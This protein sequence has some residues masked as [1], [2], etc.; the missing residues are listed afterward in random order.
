ML[1]LLHLLLGQ[2]LHLLRI[3]RH[4]RQIGWIHLLVLQGFHGK[5]LDLFG[6]L[7]EF[8]R[9]TL[10]LLLLSADFLGG[11]I[12]VLLF[13]IHLLSFLGGIQQV[14]LA[15]HQVIQLGHLALEV[16]LDELGM[17]FR[18]QDVDSHWQRA[19]LAIGPIIV[20]GHCIHINHGALGKVQCLVTGIEKKGGAAGQ[21]AGLEPGQNAAAFFHEVGAIAFPAFPFDGQLFHAVVIFTDHR[22]L[23][24]FTP[25]NGDLRGH[26]DA[27]HMMRRIVRLPLKNQF[28]RGGTGDLVLVGPSHFH[29][30]EVVE[31]QK[32]GFKNVGLNHRFLIQHLAV[33]RVGGLGL[34]HGQNAFVGL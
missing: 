4:L 15:A 3:L 19:R 17:F 30:A 11:L 31:I 6:Q 2:F 16:L 7:L 5:L 34:H 1:G 28:P 13:R 8:V 29:L 26:V 24:H 9:N 23:D 21:I 14:F 25:K 33:D 18:A 32:T 22:Y 12:L 20:L 10:L 27:V